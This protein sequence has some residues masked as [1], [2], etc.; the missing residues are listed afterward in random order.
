MPPTS[1]AS[2]PPAAPRTSPTPMSW[3]A[4]GAV[5]STSPPPTRRPPPPRSRT[6]GRDDLTY[7]PD[8]TG[9]ATGRRHGGAGQVRRRRL[10]RRAGPGTGEP[11]RRHGAALRER[12]RAG[13]GDRARAGGAG[14]LPHPRHDVLLD[15]GRPRPGPAALRR[16]HV[17]GPGLRAGGDEVP[18]PLARPHADPRPRERR[19]DDDA[20]RDRRAE[21]LNRQ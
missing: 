17:R 14:A 19:P 3:S 9:W 10:R 4:P 15:G 18:R 16:R 2:W 13:V 7:T 21:A 12:P 20:L 8:R 6:P 1:D 5:T 11:R